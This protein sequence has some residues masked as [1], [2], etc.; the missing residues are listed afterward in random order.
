MFSTPDFCY[1]SKSVYNIT[2]NYLLQACLAHA[3][4]EL[5]ELAC[6]SPVVVCCRCTPTHKE[7]VVQ[8]LKQYARK[9]TCAVG[10]LVDK[11]AHPMSDFTNVACVCV[12]V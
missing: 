11:L 10:L 7:K 2:L 3:E 4:E 8:L 6:N 1:I 12:V 5:I 9:P